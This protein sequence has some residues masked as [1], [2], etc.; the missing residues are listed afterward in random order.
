MK[1]TH[2]QGRGYDPAQRLWQTA[3]TEK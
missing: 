2:R 1:L 3:M